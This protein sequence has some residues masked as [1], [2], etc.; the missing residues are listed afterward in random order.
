MSECYDSFFFVII[1]ISV[2]VILFHFAF[3][4][5]LFPN[6]IHTANKYHL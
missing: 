5:Y 4:Y 3:L 6:D 2:F 1:L